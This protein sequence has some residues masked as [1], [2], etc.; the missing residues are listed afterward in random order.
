MVHLTPVDGSREEHLARAKR[1]TSHTTT[2]QTTSTLSG[3]RS[4]AVMAGKSQP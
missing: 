2:K 3:K 4:Q 1:F